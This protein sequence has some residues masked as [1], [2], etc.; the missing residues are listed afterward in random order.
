[1]RSKAKDICM[2]RACVGE[3]HRLAYNTSDEGRGG[4]P[5]NPP[6]STVPRWL[7]EE[8]EGGTG[9]FGVGDTK[10]PGPNVAEHRAFFETDVSTFL[11][12]QPFFFTIF[13]LNFRGILE[14]SS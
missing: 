12:K 5:R 14:S 8:S 9:R 13:C 4:H 1:M 3:S 10:P 2:F 7:S 6:S 11:K